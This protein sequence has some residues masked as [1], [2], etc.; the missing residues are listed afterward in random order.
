MFGVKKFLKMAIG[1]LCAVAGISML[2]ACGDGD[3]KDTKSS[4]Q[5]QE[6]AKCCGD[7]ESSIN[8][9]LCVDIWRDKSACPKM[10]DNDAGLKACCNTLKNDAASFA[11]CID[12]Y[13]KVN[14]CVVMADYGPAPYDK[15]NNNNN[16]DDDL[17]ACCGD[18]P[19][20]AD[21]CNKDCY[22]G[23]KAAFEDN[24]NVCPELEACNCPLP[25]CGDNCMTYY[26]PAPDMEELKACC[27][28]DFDASGFADCER[29]F[30][31][32]NNSCPVD[33]ALKNC[34]GDEPSADDT[35]N[36]NCYD[37]CKG[38][39]KANDNVCPMLSECNCPLPECNDDKCPTYYGPA[40][41]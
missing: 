26:G 35:C 4:K 3:D 10:D 15:E 13:K 22:D 19:S 23:C 36:K 18:E 41:P 21:T 16:N 32:N 7:E 31:L 28:D 24:D 38:A 27:G 12:Q 33:V 39:F 37:G 17:K 11:V 40:I 14:D 6:I 5:A 25:E 29:D 20:A 30:I 9:N 34:C 8:Y 2:S 1:G